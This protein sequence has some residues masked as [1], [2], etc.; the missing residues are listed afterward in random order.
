[1]RPQ[2]KPEIIRS[3]FAAYMSK[4]REVVEKLLADDFRFTSPYDDRIDKAAYFERCWP[5]SER[6]RSVDIESIAETDG[7]AFVLYKVAT[8]E[9]KIFRNTEL[10]TFLGNHVREVSVYFGPTYKDGVFVREQ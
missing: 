10:F 3:L 7:Q 6:M 1:M 4:N 2:S 8:D 5:N 9:G